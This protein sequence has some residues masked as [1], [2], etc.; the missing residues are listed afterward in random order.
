MHNKIIR[1]YHVDSKNDLQ[2]DETP[3]LQ[4]KA[5]PLNAS[6]DDSTYQAELSDEEKSPDH[7]PSS[8][9]KSVDEGLRSTSK[10]QPTDQE[11]QREGLTV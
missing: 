1:L 6:H 8:A 10:L 7:P 2:Y 9:K 3:Q 4:D 5:P 11:K